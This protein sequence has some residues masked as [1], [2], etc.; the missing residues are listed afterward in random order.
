MYGIGETS[1]GCPIQSEKTTIPAT[2]GRQLG[3]S[4]GQAFLVAGRGIPKN[5]KSF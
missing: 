3:P 5:Y 4:H 1:V 2:E